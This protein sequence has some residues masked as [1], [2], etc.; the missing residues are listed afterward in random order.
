MVT[1]FKCAIEGK[2]RPKAYKQKQKRKQ[3][4]KTQHWAFAHDKISRGSMES[5]F[6]FSECVF[7]STKS[8]LKT[9]R[10][11]FLEH[12]SMFQTSSLVNKINI[13]IVSCSSLWSFG[14][15]HNI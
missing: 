11:Q 3:T 15:L 14:V 4:K 13:I 2:L 6:V 1:V 5:N 12:V 9:Q 10:F 7:T 8:S